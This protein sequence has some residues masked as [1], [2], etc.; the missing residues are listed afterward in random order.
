MCCGFIE[1]RGI[2]IVIV[3]VVVIVWCCVELCLS[4]L[5]DIY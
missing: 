3:L 1:G 2:V 4:Y 5:E